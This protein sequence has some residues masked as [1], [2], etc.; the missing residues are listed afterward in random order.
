MQALMY[1]CCKSIEIRQKKPNNQ[2]PSADIEV[3]NEGGDIC[4]DE[5]D[6]FGIELASDESEDDY[7]PNDCSDDEELA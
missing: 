4:E 2:K 7:D 3:V 1:L 6:D 5:D